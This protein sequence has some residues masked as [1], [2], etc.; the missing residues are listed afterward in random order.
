M[1]VARTEFWCVSPTRAEKK[2][3]HAKAQ[4]NVLVYLSLPWRQRTLQCE[5]IPKWKNLRNTKYSERGITVLL[6]LQSK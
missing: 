5:N 6:S 3:S 2:V 4:N 1:P